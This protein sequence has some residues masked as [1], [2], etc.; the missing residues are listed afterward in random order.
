LHGVPFAEVRAISNSSARAIGRPGGYRTLAAL[1]DA[2]V[3]IMRSRCRRVAYSPCRTTR[4]SLRLDARLIDGAPPVE[5]TYADIDVTN[6][7]AEKGDFDVVKVSYAALPGYS[8]RTR[9]CRAA[10]RSAA[11][12]ARSC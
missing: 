12:A 9:C 10:V 3:A 11:A 7:A 4:S 6:T 2:F 8:S 5:I 1:R